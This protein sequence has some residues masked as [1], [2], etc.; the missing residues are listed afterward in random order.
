MKKIISRIIGQENINK[1]KD[2]IIDKLITPRKYEALT[3]AKFG[4]YM[5]KLA[6]NYNNSFCF[7]LDFI[8]AYQKA[9]KI[10]PSPNWPEIKGT[11]QLGYWV[12]YTAL[13]FAKRAMKIDGNFIEFG[14]YKGRHAAAI[15]EYVGWS[16][17]T[18]KKFYLLDTFYGL[19]RKFAEK[20]EFDSYVS[21]YKDYSLE[22]VSIHFNDYGNVKLIPGPVPDTL[23]E[24][25]EG[26]FSFAHID[27]NSAYPESKAFEYIYP[28]MATGGSI[29]FDDYAQI[30][31]EAQKISLDRM[32]E[33]F[34]EKIFSLPTGQGILIK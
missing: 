17:L 10:D 30:G 12:L 14:T 32:A 16:N 27:M 4:Y 18:P 19:D 31:H 1:I 34:G 29:L 5:E 9:M 3:R 33:S 21:A 13:F 26:R 22:S 24:I 28:R 7:E 6:C 20:D 15:L 25:P 2:I 23:V 8:K 11:D